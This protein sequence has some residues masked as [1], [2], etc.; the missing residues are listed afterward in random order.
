MSFG[1]SKVWKGSIKQLQA[2]MS[3]ISRVI[4][5]PKYR[6]IGLGE[7]IVKET[8][9]QAETANVETVAVMAKYNPFFEKAGM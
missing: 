9:S 5:H 2:E 4:V 7:K 6:S 1:R 8:L 3:I